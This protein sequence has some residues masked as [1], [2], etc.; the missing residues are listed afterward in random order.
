MK[1]TKIKIERVPVAL[2]RPLVISFGTYTEAVNWF[3]KVE[4]EDGSFG[5][6]AASPFAPVTGETA[7]SCLAVLQLFADTLT[8]CDAD[9]IKSVHEAMDR[10]I[11]GNGSAKCAIDTAL[12]DRKGKLAGMPVYRMLG[13]TDG[14]VVNDVTIG[15]DTPDEMARLALHYVQN[16]GFG[17]LKVKIG[18]DSV[19]DMEA[20]AK[21]R[22]AV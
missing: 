3:V 13:G 1:I 9:D 8:G 18:A 4:A 22:E 19:H 10:I 21:I 17:I 11:Y 16:L 15:I 6:G 7:E 5:I 12:Y 14:I 2:A 20:L